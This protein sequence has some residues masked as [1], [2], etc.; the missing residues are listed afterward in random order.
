MVVM[1]VMVAV[2]IHPAR[3]AVTISANATQ[4]RSI[5]FLAL[6]RASDL[7]HRNSSEAAG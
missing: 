6:M 3:A 2:V 1:V 5:I 4:Q 7:L